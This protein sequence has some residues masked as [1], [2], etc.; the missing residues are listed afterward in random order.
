MAAS[1]K[2]LPADQK[3]AAS[4]FLSQMTEMMSRPDAQQQLALMA[5]NN[6]MQNGPQM[7][8]SNLSLPSRNPNTQ[9]S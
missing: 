5:K 9:M 8:F 1:L 7:K 3:E 4:K 6:G 2:G